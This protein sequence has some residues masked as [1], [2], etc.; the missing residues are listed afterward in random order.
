LE[1]S[2]IAT[3]DFAVKPVDLE[4]ILAQVA[5][6]YASDIREHKIKII[7][8]KLPVLVANHG[9]MLQLFQNLIGNAIKY[10]KIDGELVIKVG[11]AL[12]N[13][14][15]QFTIADNGIGF[16]MKFSGKIFV[17]F[18]RLH[19]KETYPGTGIGLAICKKILSKHHGDIWAQAEPGKGSTF[20]FT[21]PQNLGIIYNERN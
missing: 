13:N 3:K 1:Y 11:A 8:E 12:V 5:Q 10:R 17:I 6:L 14:K 9:Q 16:D 18:Q 4:E 7:K 21:I 2:R 15:Y 19:L 20:Y